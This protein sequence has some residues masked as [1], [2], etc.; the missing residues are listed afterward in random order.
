[1]SLEKELRSAIQSGA[2]KIGSAS[3]IRGIKKGKG[4]L[5]ILAKNCSAGQKQTIDTYSKMAGIS[6]HIFDGTSMELG[7]LCKK[8]HSVM[9]MLIEDAGNSELLNEIKRKN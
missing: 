2:V 6:I 1:M 3:T 7:G 9:A 4:Q 8:P 5:V